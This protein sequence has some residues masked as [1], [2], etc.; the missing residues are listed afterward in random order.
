MLTF[1]HKTDV[2]ELHADA[3][4]GTQ[5]YTDIPDLDQ[6]IQNYGAGG[7]YKTERFDW[8]LTANYSV[9]PSRNTARTSSGVFNTN[10]DREEWSIKP[11]ITFK[12]D[13]IDSIVLTPSYSETTFSNT[14]NADPNDFNNDFNNYDATNIDLAWKRYWS[15]PYNSEVSLFYSN[16]NSTPQRQNSQ[17]VA[18]SFDSMGI[19]FANTY[20]WSDNWKVLGT[21]G[22]R[23]TEATTNGSSESSFGFLADMEV[24][25]TGENFVSGINFSRSLTPSNQGQLQELTSVGIDFTYDILEHLSARLTTNYLHSTLVNQTTTPADGSD[26]QTRDSILVQPSVNWE[27]RPEWTL[28]GGYRY[29]SQDIKTQNDITNDGFADSNLFYISI[30]YNWQGLKLKRSSWN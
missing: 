26:Q 11:S 23:Y 22:A 5:I 8:G 28:S 19:N 30:N 21:I 6:D 24:D 16:F 3:L 15:V 20:S 27:L 9:T 10:S 4:Y 25:Y 1:Q 14:A 13:E 18:S 7:V 17:S 12:I 29:R 2:S